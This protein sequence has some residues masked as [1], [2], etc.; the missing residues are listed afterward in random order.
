[1]INIKFQKYKIFFLIKLCRVGEGLFLI[2]KNLK[3]NITFFKIY[4]LF[5]K[6][7]YVFIIYIMNDYNCDGFYHEPLYTPHLANLKELKK[8]AL[9]KIYTYPIDKNLKW[10]KPFPEFPNA[11][12]DKYFFK[13][14]YIDAINRK[15]AN[16]QNQLYM[17]QMREVIDNDI[18]LEEMKIEDRKIQQLNNYFKLS[19]FSSFMNQVKDGYLKSQA[20]ELEKNNTAL[21][22]AEKQRARIEEQDR[23]KLTL[24]SENADIRLELKKIDDSISSVVDELLQEENFDELEKV[25]D[26]LDEFSDISK[27]PE[28]EGNIDNYINETLAEVGSLQES[29]LSEVLS[30]ISEATEQEL[31]QET[32]EQKI[33]KQQLEEKKIA[34]E[35]AYRAKQV[36]EDRKL[37]IGDIKGKI[38]KQ[39][40]INDVYTDELDK[41]RKNFMK[42]DKGIKKGLEKTRD[43]LEFVKVSNEL[44]FLD[45]N[46]YDIIKNNFPDLRVSTKRERD[47][48]RNNMND[49][50]KT[51]RSGNRINYKTFMENIKMENIISGLEKQ[52]YNM[53]FKPKSIAKLENELKNYK[54]IKIAKLGV[55]EGTSLL[56]AGENLQN[57]AEKL[58][59]ID[60]AGLLPSSLPEGAVF[61]DLPPTTEQ[62]TP[63]PEFEEEGGAN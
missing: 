55:R 17:E 53:E 20:Q 60:L 6:I 8:P 35:K 7:I 31:Q 4:I 19:L 45:N 3:K 42:F 39:K 5:L 27:Y 34:Q 29:E 9:T 43:I 33:L 36:A 13:Y 18:E 46:E 11:D 63:F 40:N 41:I 2:F 23:K 59:N 10:Y 62:T 26:I 54:K 61:E 16:L 32:E 52:P 37:R 51:I 15:I 30:K 50:F 38:E 48:I 14:E 44:R 22:D 56:S 57:Q 47:N 49:L 25:K 24:E 28:T 1:M 21:L 58:L 12:Q